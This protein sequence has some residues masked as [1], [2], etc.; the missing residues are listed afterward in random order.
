M[1]LTLQFYDFVNVIK[2]EFRTM[3][4]LERRSLLQLRIVK[5]VQQRFVWKCSGVLMEG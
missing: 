3:L 2:S 1:L 4:Y 5:R